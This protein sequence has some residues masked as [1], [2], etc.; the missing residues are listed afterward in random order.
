MEKDED[1]ST[2]SGQR[3][4]GTREGKTRRS[5]DIGAGRVSAAKNSLREDLTV[6]ETIEAIVELVDV[7]FEDDVEYASMGPNSVDRVKTLLGKL[8]S[9][10]MSTNRGSQVSEERIAVWQ[11]CQTGSDNLQ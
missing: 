3:R 1:P 10:M 8:H 2:S 4:E 9:T 11:I 7:E 6:F 5:N